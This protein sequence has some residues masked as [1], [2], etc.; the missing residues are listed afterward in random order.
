MKTTLGYGFTIGSNGYSEV[1]VRWDKLTC[2]MMTNEAFREE[3]YL[4]PLV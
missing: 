2:Y 1:W 3:K 4:T